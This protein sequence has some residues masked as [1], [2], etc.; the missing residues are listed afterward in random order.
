MKGRLQVKVV[1]REVLPDSSIGRSADVSAVGEEVMV[2][3]YIDTLVSYLEEVGFEYV[4][5]YEFSL[6][7]SI[8]YEK[9]IDGKYVMVEI[10]YGLDVIYEDFVDWWLDSGDSISG[11]VED[12]KYLIKRYGGVN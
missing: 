11:A 2:K 1:V 5:S 8:T 3:K 9:A 12:V 4:D 7:G 10:I 6:E